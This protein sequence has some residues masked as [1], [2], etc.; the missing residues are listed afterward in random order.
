MKEDELLEEAVECI[1]MLSGWYGVLCECGHPACKR[2]KE[3]VEVKAFLQKYNTY[4]G[5]P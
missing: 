2:C 4:K 3:A 1:Y 5:V